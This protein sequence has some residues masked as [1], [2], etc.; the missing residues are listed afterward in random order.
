[1]DEL[2]R[3]R[4]RN[5]FGK[6]QELP[7]GQ[8]NTTGI[9]APSPYR[10]PNW[11]PNV[12]NPP[13]T[14]MAGILRSAKAQD[15]YDEY[16]KNA[17]KRSD[18]QLSKLGKALAAIAGVTEGATSGATKGIAT[19]TG[20]LNRRYQEALEDYSTKGG[21]LKERADL[22][23]RNMTDAEKRQQAERKYQL[24]L[25]KQLADEIKTS[26]DIKV[27]EAQVRNLDNMIRNRGLSLQ[28]N[29]VDGHLYVVDQAAGTSM[30]MGQFM[31][32]PEAK[33]AL[34][35]KFFKVEEGIRQTGRKELQEDQQAHAIS[36]EGIRA[37]NAA[38]LAR[39]RSQLGRGDAEFKAEL[40]KMTPQAQATAFKL[41]TEQAVN[42]GFV[43][44]PKNV[45]PFM[46]AVRERLDNIRVRAGGKPTVTL[47][48]NVP[49][50]VNNPQMDSALRESALAYI[51]DNY[52]DDPNL[53][54]NEDA[55]RHVMDKLKEQVP[56]IPATPTVTL[57]PASNLSSPLMSPNF[58]QFNAGGFNSQ[59]IDPLRQAGTNFMAGVNELPHLANRI[60]RY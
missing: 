43:Y 6:V 12:V 22:E 42:D 32:T 39:L 27:N 20:L 9:F 35:H 14:G 28:R 11:N 40:D 5:I 45:G 4:L 48:N 8:I 53:L 10:T 21:I 15:E 50:P 30:S 16:L 51:R 46:T 13:D 24:D 52:P 29:E 58:G 3:L 54:T 2:Q 17:P 37:G 44:D 60:P 23:Y 56:Q 38:D 18:Y 36:I 34:E 59:I 33:R 41:A 57:P 19:G 31:Q 49:P 25:R 55:I 26:S 7:Q 47:P 1:M